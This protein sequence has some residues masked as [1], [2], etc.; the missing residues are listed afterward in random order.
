MSFSLKSLK[1]VFVYIASIQAII[2]GEMFERRMSGVQRVVVYLR[3]GW[4]RQLQEGERELQMAVTEVMILSCDIL[5]HCSV[6][7]HCST[8]LLLDCCWSEI[9]A[10][11]CH[12]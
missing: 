11:V 5:L 6:P 1:S 3:R 2:I 4:W 7:L 12:L 10:V 9:T 8:R